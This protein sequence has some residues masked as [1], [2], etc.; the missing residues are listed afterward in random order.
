MP[1]GGEDLRSQ[2]QLLH[3]LKMLAPLSPTGQCKIRPCPFMTAHRCQTFYHMFIKP[4]ERCVNWNET[5]A[6]GMEM[7]AL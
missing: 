7:R 2:N 6:Y 5:W 3:P 1:Y 4:T